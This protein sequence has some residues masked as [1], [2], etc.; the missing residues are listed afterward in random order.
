MLP[1]RLLPPL[2][3]LTFAACATVD[4]GPMQRIRVDSQPAGANVTTI[5]CGPGSTKKARTPAVVWVNRRAS[6]C[7]ITFS[8]IGYESETFRLQRRISDATSENIRF[9][10]GLC[11]EEALDCNSASDWFGVILISA[12]VSGTGI[13]VDAL[14]GAMF[15]QEPN[16][17]VAN[18]CPQEWRTR[19][20]P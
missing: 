6:R 14:S 11:T 10:D 9:L 13:G 3:A 7:A 16:E 1:G 18:L 4:H 5:D 20:D 19:T 2:L 8:A 15:E 12:A 17:I